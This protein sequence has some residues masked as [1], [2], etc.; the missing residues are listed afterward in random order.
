MEPLAETENSKNRDAAHCGTAFYRSII[1]KNDDN[2]DENNQGRTR[3][4]HEWG[5]LLLLHLLAFPF[6]NALHCTQPN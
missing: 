6:L 3:A 4:P 1:D 5:A 2:N